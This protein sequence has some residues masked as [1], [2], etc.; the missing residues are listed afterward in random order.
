M[1]SI[2]C[3]SNTIQARIQMIQNNAGGE[4]QIAQ[5]DMLYLFGYC[6]FCAT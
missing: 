3:N 1:N 4:V 5:L 6:I 2:T